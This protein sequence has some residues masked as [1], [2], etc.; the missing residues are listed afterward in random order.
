MSQAILTVSSN[1]N[2]DLIDETHKRARAAILRPVP[3]AK[4]LKSVPRRTLDNIA[5]F[6]TDRIWRTFNDPDG[7][8]T[9]SAAIQTTHIAKSAVQNALSWSTAFT[10]ARQTFQQYFPEYKFDI[11]FKMPRD[12][13]AQ[14]DKKNK[15]LNNELYLIIEP[16]LRLVFKD[17]VDRFKQEQANERQRQIEAR[18]EAERREI[19]RIRDERLHKKS[20]EEEEEVVAAAPVPVISHAALYAVLE[21]IDENEWD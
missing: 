10:L 5:T 17:V 15:I 19:Q 13:K 3:F 20:V 18:A 9:D 7:F 16:V 14:L 8:R 4:S 1:M 11:K 12:V 2:V 6:V 21:G